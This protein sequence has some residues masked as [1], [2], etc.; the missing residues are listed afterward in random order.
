M[1]RL[2][3]GCRSAVIALA[4]LIAASGA[5]LATSSPP[6]EPPPPPG[7][8]EAPLDY[9]PPAPNPPPPYPLPAVGQPPPPPSSPVMRVIYA[10]FYAAGLVLHYGFYYGI[11]VPFQVFGRALT[12]GVDSES[13][14]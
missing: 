9:P 14:G 5:A 7:S 13:G 1:S 3:H 10:P 2:K 12:Y 6:P 8:Y 4:V 11:V